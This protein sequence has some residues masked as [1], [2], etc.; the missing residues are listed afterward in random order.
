MFEIRSILLIAALFAVGFFGV[1]WVAAGAPVPVFRV[2]PLKPD[3][4]LPT[5]HQYDPR[6]DRK[7]WVESKTWQG[8]G[9][10]DRDKLRQALIEAATA[11]QLSPCNESLKRE[12]LTAALAYGR[13]F[14][15][16]MGCQN[17][18]VC[19]TDDARREQAIQAFGS[20]YDKRV[21]QAIAA[22]HRMGG[23][24]R[25]DYPDKFGSLLATMAGQGFG[26]LDEKVACAAKSRQ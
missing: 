4:R 19:M 5:F 14:R 26:E 13:A 3:A 1:R 7:G 23:V 21:K 25:N 17:D 15:L 11:Y 24:V 2:E 18:Q 9:D 8:D 20:P 16:A 12:F 10:A 6:T 22:V